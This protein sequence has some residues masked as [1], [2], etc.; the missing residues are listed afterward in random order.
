MWKHFT[1][2]EKQYIQSRYQSVIPSVHESPPV[3]CSL[4]PLVWFQPCS[5]Q[6]KVESFLLTKQM[7]GQRVWSLP[8]RALMGLARS[9]QVRFHPLIP[10]GSSVCHIP[11]QSLS[12][13]PQLPLPNGSHHG[14]LTSL[15]ASFTTASSL[16][17]STFV[18][19]VCS[20]HNNKTHL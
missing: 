7:V 12:K 10:L 19:M 17:P 16:V 4:T 8:L 15:S 3:P 5:S 13:P 20:P 18:P 14:L 1:E 9:I 11:I 2:Y 6:A